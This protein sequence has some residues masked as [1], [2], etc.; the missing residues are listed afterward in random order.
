M[1]RARLLRESLPG[2]NVVGIDCDNNDQNII[3][4]SGAIHC[5]TKGI[6]VA[7][8]LLI[9]HQRL[10]DTY[11]TVQPYIVDAYIRHRS[12]I[13]AA[14]VYWTT[15]TAAGFTSVP[16]TAGPNN[17]WTAGIPAQVAG[18]DVFYYIH[19]AANSGKQ[20]VRPIVAPQGWWKFRVLDINTG[21]A[22]G[23]AP[24][25][26]EVFPN[27]TAGILV[28]TV[29]DAGSQR[30]RITL[31]DAQGREVLRIQD[32]PMHQDQRAF[33]D[34]SGLAEGA[35]LLVVES[36]TGRSTTRVLRN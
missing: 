28:V 19:A 10:S 26:A 32:G 24:V 15:D 3:S 21:I 20:Q 7:D 16:M 36:A 34:L 35:Y 9:K 29:N 23:A 13:A 14:E 11:E 27:P 12:D 4:A 31:R 6:G 17:T 18:S 25:I 1:H 5:I 30:V 2:Y 33:A 8:P 22:G